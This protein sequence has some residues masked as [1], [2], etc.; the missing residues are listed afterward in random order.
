MAMPPVL[1]NK[2]S[3]Y[4]NILLKN[5]EEILKENGLIIDLTGYY[6][7]MLKLYSLEMSDVAGAW[8]LSM[9]LNAWSDY[10]GDIR[11]NCKKILSDLEAEKMSTIAAAS[12]SAD[13]GK[14]ANGDRLANKDEKVVQI[15]KKRNTMQSLCDLLDS[16]VIYLER[17][18]YMCKKTFEIANEVAK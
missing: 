1:K 13:K 15:R 12:L 3:S 11:S 8:E 18:H 14:V 4:L 6:E 2:D 10:L 16:K 17:A 7:T 9:E 5:A